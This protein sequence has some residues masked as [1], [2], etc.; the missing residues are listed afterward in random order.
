MATVA[1]NGLAALWSGT[2]VTWGADDLAAYRFVEDAVD[3]GPLTQAVDDGG[4][5]TATGS[6][7]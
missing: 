4:R 3:L 6:T 5:L 1:W 2:A 7:R